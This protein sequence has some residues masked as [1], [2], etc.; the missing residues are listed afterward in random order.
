MRIAVTGASGLIGSAAVPA[1]RA[2]GHEVLRFVRRPAAAPDEL[3][4]DPAQRKLD[5]ADLTAVDAVLHLAGVG[6][7]D[8]RWNEAHKRAVRESRVDGTLT[9]SHAIAAAEPQPRVL[10]SSSAVGW[11]GDTGDRV[12]DESEPA[13]TGFLP[14]VVRDWEEATGPARAAGARVVL[15][16]TGLVCAP[17]GGVLG[18]MKPLAK[19]ALLS[20]LGS[21]RQY[22]PWISLVDEVDAMRFLLGADDVSGPVNL[23]GPDPATNADFTAALRKVLGRPRLAPRV[24]PFALR[25]AL[26]EFADEGVLVGARAVPRVLQSAGYRFT[27]PTLTAALRW[28]TGRSDVG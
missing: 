22:Q 7:A 18:P 9:V 19:L 25:L 3:S 26:G 20:P 10:L 24:P 4:W 5:P 14:G 27:H 23:T 21:G 6:I 15:M 8:R 28:A 12:V 11:Y 17:K 13:G 1:L 2:D 16:R